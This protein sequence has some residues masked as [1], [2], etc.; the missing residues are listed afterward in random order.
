M[1]VVPTPNATHKWRPNRLK[2]SVTAVYCIP[3][4]IHPYLV[5]AVNASALL[6]VLYTQ[7]NAQKDIM[8]AQQSTQPHHLKV[9]RPAPPPRLSTLDFPPLQRCTICLDFKLFFPAC[10]PTSGC[11]HLIEVCPSCLET[12]VCLGI[13]DGICLNCPTVGCSSQMDVSE[14]RTSLGDGH[15]EEFEKQVKPDCTSDVPELITFAILD[16]ARG[17]FDTSFKPKRRWYGAGRRSVVQARSML[18]EPLGQS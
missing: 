8:G 2:S 12:Y 9:K 15:K 11:A 3:I 13:K 17:R 7:P 18:V 14:I 10:P 1:G 16:F 5:P 4:T 6:A